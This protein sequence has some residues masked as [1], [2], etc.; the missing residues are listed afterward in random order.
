MPN[1]KK[2]K[3]ISVILPF[4]LFLFLL[5]YS[6]QSRH[7]MTELYAGTSYYIIFHFVW[8]GYFNLFAF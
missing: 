6:F 4:I 2:F 7:T 3:W 1:Y 8:F 5:I